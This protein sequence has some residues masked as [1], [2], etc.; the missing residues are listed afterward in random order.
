[1][2]EVNIRPVERARRTSA[3][4]HLRALRRAD[5]DLVR[6]D[7]ARR[8]GIRAPDRQEPRAVAMARG[9]SRRGTRR[10]RVR[11][12]A[13]RTTGLPMVRGGV[14]LCSL[15][16]PSPGHR[17]SASTRRSSPISPSAASVMRSPASR[18]PMR[19]ASLSTPALASR[20]SGYSERSA[21]SSAAGT[22]SPGSS[23]GFASHRLADHPLGPAKRVS[24][25]CG[26]GRD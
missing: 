4:G 20:R 18:C 7:P 26:G 17:A 19:R 8:A 1:M 10:V 13:P 6:R 14:G 16:P 23:A 12:S 5:G 9:R 11:L 22:M 21:G 3:G 25:P 2:P 15:R 24:R